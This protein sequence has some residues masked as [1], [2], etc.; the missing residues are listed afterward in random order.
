ML[1]LTPEAFLESLEDRILNSAS[2]AF[3]PWLNIL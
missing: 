3:T 2:C 1:E